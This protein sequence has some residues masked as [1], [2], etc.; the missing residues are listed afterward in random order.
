MHQARKSKNTKEYNEAIPS[1]EKGP[2]KGEIKP[3]EA[4]EVMQGEEY[5]LWLKMQE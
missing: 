4:D 1:T 2:E 5:E 3:S